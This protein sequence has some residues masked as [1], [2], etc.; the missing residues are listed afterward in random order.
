M[1]TN[2]MLEHHVLLHILFNPW[3]WRGVVPFGQY[4]GTNHV[5]DGAAEVFTVTKC[6]RYNKK[7]TSTMSFG[8]N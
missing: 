2:F 5:Y 8:Q 6:K 4:G 1:L 7:E 3:G